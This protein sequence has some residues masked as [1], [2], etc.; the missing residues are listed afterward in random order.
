MRAERK[1]HDCLGYKIFYF[2]YSYSTA[3]PLFILLT[4]S[5]ARLLEPRG[6]LGIAI[7]TRIAGKF[8]LKP[9]SNKI[10]MILRS[11][12]MAAKMFSWQIFALSD[13]GRQA[14]IK[15][16]SHRHRRRKRVTI[17][18]RIFVGVIGTQMA[19]VARG[20]SILAL[21]AKLMRTAF[22][23]SANDVML[24]LVWY[25]QAGKSLM[26]FWCIMSHPSPDIKV[27][28]DLDYEKDFY[29][30]SKNRQR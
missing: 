25:T 12:T 26:K 6:S 7:C 29:I 11:V 8:E 1:R 13:S 2:M 20:G 5:R 27:T 3:V 28:A 18:T 17:A 24:F 22:G 14:T 21:N 9:V 30:I 4:T 19:S 23:E 16:I 15:A 10:S